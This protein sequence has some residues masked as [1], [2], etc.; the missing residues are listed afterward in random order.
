V[1]RIVLYSSDGCELC[2][3]AR[4]LLDLIGEPFAVRHDPAFAARVPVIAVDGRIVTE[5]RISERAV[6]RALR[7]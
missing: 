1:T 2:D 5:G 3:D 4:A 6:R 7:R